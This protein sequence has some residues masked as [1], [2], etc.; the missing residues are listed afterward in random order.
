MKYLRESLGEFTGTFFLVLFGLSSVAV[1]FCFDEYKGIFQIGIVWGIGL[2]L[3]IY[4]TRHICCAHFNPAVTLAM[5]V[6]KRCSWKKVPSYI[7]SQ[8]LGAFAGG[9]LV[10]GLFGSNIAKTE[11]LLGIVRGS[12]GSYQSAKM[13]GEYYAFSGIS[14]FCHSSG[15]AFHA[16]ARMLWLNSFG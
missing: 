6:C 12:E 3:T 13:F 7:I 2:A 14:M 5:A 15:A 1:S 16:A 10:Y 11:A 4:A 8:F 9:L